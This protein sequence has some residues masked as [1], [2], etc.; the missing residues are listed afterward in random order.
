MSNYTCI[1]CGLK[2]G[3]K[4]DLRKHIQQ[5]KIC[6]ANIKN[7]NRRDLYEYY[8]DLLFKDYNGKVS[9]KKINNMCRYCDKEFSSYKNKWRHEKDHCDK[10][11]QLENINNVNSNID[12]VNGNAAS[13]NNGTMNDNSVT[14]NITNNINI[15]PLGQENI[16]Q[17]LT[18]NEQLAILNKGYNSI[19]ESIDY[20]HFNNRYPQ[21]K[22][23]KINNL[24]DG[25][26]QIYDDKKDKFLT[27][28]KDKLIDDILY[29]RLDDLQEMYENNK[30][31]LN[32]RTKKVILELIEKL[33]NDEGT[34]FVKDKRLDILLVIYNGSEE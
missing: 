15:V 4:N 33:G 19:N 27:I 31:K 9:S 29:Y 2:L 22:C 17:V 34:K 6:E 3:C 12:T 28:T 11:K 25:F 10:I 23:I 14:N 8:Y 13:I 20:I 21:F 18:K 24:K 1:R 16:L 5:K 30:T 32:E 7:I 26:G